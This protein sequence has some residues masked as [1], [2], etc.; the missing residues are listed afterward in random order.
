MGRRVSDLHSDLSFQHV[1][2]S[3]IFLLPYITIVG[4]PKSRRSTGISIDGIEADSGPTSIVA[5][6]VSTCEGDLVTIVT[7]YRIRSIGDWVLKR[8]LGDCGDVRVSLMLYIPFL[9]I[10]ISSLCRAMHLVDLD[11]SN[12]CMGRRT[13]DPVGR[14]VTTDRPNM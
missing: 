3:V 7:R 9:D 2:S 14:T 4:L 12:W 1:I 6:S 5:G 8:G 13:S 10:S 11:G